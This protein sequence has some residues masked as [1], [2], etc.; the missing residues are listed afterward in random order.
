MILIE[1]RAAKRSIRLVLCLYSSQVHLTATFEQ[2]QLYNDTLLYLKCLME[3]FFT[4]KLNLL[5]CGPFLLGHC[6]AGAAVSVFASFY[7]EIALRQRSA[8]GV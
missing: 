1:V 4:A 2:Q 3:A 8:V 6:F 7:L 5:H